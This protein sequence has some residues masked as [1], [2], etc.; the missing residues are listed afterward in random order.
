MLSLG[1]WQLMFAWILTF[2][3][4]VFFIRRIVGDLVEVSRFTP[5]CFLVFVLECGCIP[6]TD[7]LLSRQSSFCRLEAWISV[8]FCV[9][10][11]VHYLAFQTEF[12]T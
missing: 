3:I 2:L 7:L 12:I 10:D 8:N 6:V 11:P 5:L 9:K 1:I 4:V